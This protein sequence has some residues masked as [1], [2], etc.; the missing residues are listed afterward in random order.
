MRASDGRGHADA[1][2]FA[3]YRTRKARVRMP[4]IESFKVLKE[5]LR[6]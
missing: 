2:R 3:L 5:G 4:F 1:N 6:L